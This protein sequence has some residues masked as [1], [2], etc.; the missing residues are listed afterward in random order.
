MLGVVLVGPCSMG[1][2]HIRAERRFHGVEIEA[3]VNANGVDTSQAPGMPVAG[4][5][6]GALVT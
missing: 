5:V 6:L 1:A 4:R 2:N 3:F